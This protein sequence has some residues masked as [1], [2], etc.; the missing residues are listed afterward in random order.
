MGWR[1]YQSGKFNAR[2]SSLHKNYTPR[3][4]PSGSDG[5]SVFESTPQGLVF[6]SPQGEYLKVSWGGLDWYG[7]ASFPEVW[8]A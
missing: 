7:C 5:Y 2:G 6:N 3:G 8:V 1:E 4:S